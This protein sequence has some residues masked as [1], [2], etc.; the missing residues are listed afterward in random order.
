[1]WRLPPRPE[2]TTPKAPD[3]LSP[4]HLLLAGLGIWVAAHIGGAVVLATIGATPADAS[5]SLRDT[6]FALLGMYAAAALMLVVIVLRWPAV[7][8]QTGLLVARRDPLIAFGWLALAMPILLTLGVVLRALVSALQGTPPDATAHE[9]LAALQRENDSTW[10]LGVIV[11]VSVGAPIVE[12]IIFRGFIQSSIRAAA[13][14]TASGAWI[15]VGMTSIV[16]TL[17]H[18]GEV[19]WYALPVLTCLSA[20]LG[21]AFERSGRLGVPIVMHGLFNILQLAYSLT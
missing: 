17:I 18:M 6:T 2:L 7:R 10:R 12:E 1:M 14:A 16:F 20:F 11:L 5:P 15:A 21:A 4:A 3:R 13:G 9:T 8:A 19:A